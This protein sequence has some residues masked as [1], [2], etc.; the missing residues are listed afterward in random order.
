MKV[1]TDKN[2]DG[3]DR[4]YID[5][6]ISILLNGFSSLR[7]ANFQVGRSDCGSFFNESEPTSCRDA[8]PFYRPIQNCFKEI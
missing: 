8:S 3:Y 4:D 7:D 1:E 6:I 5:V 2:I